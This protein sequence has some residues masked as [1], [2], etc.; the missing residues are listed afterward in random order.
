MS[1]DLRILHACPHRVVEEILDLGLDTQT[2]RVPRFIA[3]K[4]AVQLL[5]NGTILIPQG[6]LHSP[7]RVVGSKI[8][9]FD[10]STGVNDLLSFRVD[11]GPRQTL[12]LFHG[13]QV[14]TEDLVVA[15]NVQ[16]QGVEFSSSYDH[17][18]MTSHTHGSGSTIFLEPIQD[19]TT[20]EDIGTGHVLLGLPNRYEVRGQEVI[21]AWTIENV[22]GTIPPL[23]PS[24]I[25]F[26]A[27]LRSPSNF[28]E[29]TYYTSLE[30][31]PRCHGIGIEH[32]FVP[33][34]LGDPDIVEDEELLLQMI[35]K[36]ILTVLGSDPFA[37]WYGTDLITLTGSKAVPFIRKEV[38]RQIA[39]ALAKLQ[40]IQSQQQKIQ[41]VT[42]GEFLAR[43]DQVNV[44]QA[45]SISPTLFL[46]N[47]TITARSGIQREVAQAI[48]FGGP[49]DLLGPPNPS[50]NVEA[51]I[52][53]QT[54]LLRRA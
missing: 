6:G 35:E 21:P 41:I 37:P 19:D 51:L 50:A 27:P 9:P 4:S 7:A 17:I 36:I 54:G 34:D 39:T 53:Q 25:R 14:R 44:V 5:M 13:E 28:F 8:G 29:L 47:V 30:V 18:I 1:Y 3:N 22:P 26:V 43:V 10:I 48:N 16:A 42:H 15:L 40:N 38:R 45:T 31:C 24:Q 32:D 11:G 2:M 46:V 52:D 23:Q 33:S 12:S 20:G 49:V